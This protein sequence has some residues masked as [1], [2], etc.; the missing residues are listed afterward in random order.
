[1]N[2]R[3]FAPFLV[4]LGVALGPPALASATTI[5][6]DTRADEPG[7][8]PAN[9]N[10]TLRE[11]VIA[12]NTDAA[13]DGCPA[14]DGADVIRLRGGTYQLSV[15]GGDPMP[16]SSE[17]DARIG[18][19]DLGASG[20][21]PLTIQGHASGSTIDGGNLD[22]VFDLYGSRATLRG[23]TITNGRSQYNYGGGVRAAE[24][25]ELR[26]IDSE[27]SSSL[28]LGGGN[29]GG[30]GGAYVANS[31]LTLIRTVVADNAGLHSGGLES[32]DAELELRDSVVR[33]NGAEEGPG[34]IYSGSSTL[35]VT[36]S[37][38]DGNAGWDG[39]GINALKSSVS[40][41]DTRVFGNHAARDGGGIFIGDGGTT[42]IEG[43]EIFSN[44]SDD[45]GGGLTVGDSGIASLEFDLVNSTVS[46]NTAD[47][48][49]S[50]GGRGGGLMLFALVHEG[51]SR[52]S[53]STVAN[54]HADNGGGITGGSS[55]GEYARIKGT[56]VAGNTHDYSTESGDCRNG[57]VSEGRN[58]LQDVVLES[59]GCVLTPK[60]SDQL[61]VDAKVAPLADNGG[62]TWTHA[63][64]AGS[65]AI[66][67][68]AGAPSVDQRGVPRNKPDVGAYERT[69][70]AGVL[71]NIVGTGGADTLRGTNGRDG[72]LGLG[73]KDRIRSRGGKDGVCAGGGRDR[74]NGGG[75]RDKLRGEA[76]RDVLA[77][78]SGRDVC[79]GGPGRDKA[80]G[81]CERTPGVP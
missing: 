75:G 21:G 81:S 19:L 34:G 73:G 50:S 29:A 54:N 48:D 67:A 26:V 46:G 55:P 65:P 36:R 27:I 3:H 39:G 25:A 59:W 40:I 69:K 64:L 1:M 8:A 66:N 20:S 58:V 49:D 63:L 57:L 42:L 51:H 28:A 10:C 13:K 2:L 30:G 60:P 6:P 15:A 23:L 41:S 7:S 38:V 5:R 61:N 24:G 35:T 43:S 31:E 80:K 18:D 74:I 37:L 22:R 78:G 14:G 9:G 45:D 12:A 53:S 11:A 70:C 47:A 56:L 72:I 71:V 17:A 77:G 76:G 79:S 68:G 32:Y 44:T 16:G 52:V 4:V 62:P 33:D